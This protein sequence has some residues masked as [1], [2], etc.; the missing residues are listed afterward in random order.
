VLAELVTVHS[1]GLSGL[2]LTQDV[3]GAT[4]TAEQLSAMAS[5]DRHPVDPR[6]GYLIAPEDGMAT[7]WALRYRRTDVGSNLDPSRPWQV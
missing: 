7:I 5:T 6:G 2:A 3:N 1:A 4:I